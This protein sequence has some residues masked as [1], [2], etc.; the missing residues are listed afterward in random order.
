[1]G[2]REDINRPL[3]EIQNTFLRR[4]VLIITSTIMI[5]VSIVAGTAYLIIKYVLPEVRLMFVSCWNG[6]KCP[7]II[8][9]NNEER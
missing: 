1:M 6:E 2:L 5:P 8:S 3:D 9:E 7:D 4:S